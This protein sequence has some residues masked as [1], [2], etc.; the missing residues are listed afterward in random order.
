M[1]VVLVE[2]NTRSDRRAPG[3][4]TDAMCPGDP[5]SS[6]GENGGETREETPLETR[7]DVALKGR[8]VDVDDNGDP[9]VIMSTGAYQPSSSSSEPKRVAVVVEVEE[10]TSSA[11]GIGDDETGI[12]RV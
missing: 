4:S 1:E 3:R 8:R 10:E 11:K 6:K 5:V 9:S 2:V 7:D 12:V